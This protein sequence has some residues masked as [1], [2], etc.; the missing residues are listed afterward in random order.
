MNL[1]QLAIKQNIANFNIE[2]FKRNQLT[3]YLLADKLDA[4]SLDIIQQMKSV[5][6]YKFED[7]RSIDQI[8]RNAA[9][10]VR[11]LDNV[12]TEEYSCH[13]GDIADELGVLIDGFISDKTTIDH[14]PVL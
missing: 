2:Q 3:L 7:K 4:V 1:Q 12:C 14:K 9:S 13:F 11:D 6:I 10:L 8:R 5:G